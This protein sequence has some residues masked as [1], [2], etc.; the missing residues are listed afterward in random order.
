MRSVNE[1]YQKQL[2]LLGRTFTKRDVFLGPWT[3]QTIESWD[4]EVRKNEASILGEF[5]ELE[6]EAIDKVKDYLAHK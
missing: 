3:G 5:L 1:I 4:S 2:Q 6:V